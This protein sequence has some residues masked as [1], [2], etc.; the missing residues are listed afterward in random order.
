MTTAPPL[1]AGG[2]F[3]QRGAAALLRSRRILLSSS[4]G[5]LGNALLAQV[6]QTTAAVCVEEHVDNVGIYARTRYY[7]AEDWTP[8]KLEV[9]VPLP[10]TLD[11]EHL[12]GTGAAAGEVLQPEDDQDRAGGP[13]QQQ[14]SWGATKWSLARC[15]SSSSFPSAH[16]EP[17]LSPAR[18][19]GSRRRSGG[20]G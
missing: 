16:V 4:K 13:Q 1:P 3:R 9:E 11:L 18:L 2:V 15:V 14:V 5:G 17:L 6:A 12:R 8:K 7:V 19:L 20:T 10:D